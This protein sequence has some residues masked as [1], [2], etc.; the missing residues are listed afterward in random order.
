MLELKFALGN[1]YMTK[2]VVGM[3]KF[4]IFFV[5]SDKIVVISKKREKD[6]KERFWFVNFLLTLK[7]RL[8]ACVAS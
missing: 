3:W 6:L 2:D 1:E 7:V 4:N 5:S 8:G